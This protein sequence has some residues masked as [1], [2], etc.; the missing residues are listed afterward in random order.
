MSRV[1]V[2]PARG[3]SRRI[4]RKAIREFHGKPMI[5]YPIR[6]ALA[7]KMFGRIIV[8]T[9]DSEIASYAELFGAEVLLRPA[10]LAEDEVGTQEVM[11][12]VLQRV[13]CPRHACCIYPCSPMLNG[14]DLWRCFH[15][16]TRSGADFAYCP[17]V[18]YWGRVGAFLE[19]RPLGHWVYVMD[20]GRAIDI[21]VESD[22]IAAERRYAE[23]NNRVAA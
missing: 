12:H 18:V 2:I 5:S 3:G 6:A 21:N 17:G 8:S 13:E 19:D 7:S 9:E 22:W 10:D 23:L 1:A 16:M 4:P 14:K 20:K 11:R 15:L